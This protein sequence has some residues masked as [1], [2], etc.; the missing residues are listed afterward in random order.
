MGF[1]FRKSIKAGPLRV[2]ISKSGIGYSVGVKG[3]RITKTAKGNTR[4]TLSIPGTG[5]S[6]VSETSNKQKGKGNK[7][8]YKIESTIKTAEKDVVFVKDPQ[9]EGVPTKKEK[10]KFILVFWI[11]FASVFAT[12]GI[13]SILFPLIAIQ[14]GIYCYKNSCW[15]KG[16]LP[17][18]N[19]IPYEQWFERHTPA[20]TDYMDKNLTQQQIETY[21]KVL[22][23]CDF[24]ENIEKEFTLAELNIALN[25]TITSYALNKLYELGFLIKPQRG[26]F[27]LN[28]IRITELKGKLEGCIALERQRYQNIVESCDQ[29]NNYAREYNLKIIENRYKYLCL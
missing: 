6:Y 17:L 8:Q 16:F 9:T 19:P 10:N 15:R 20:L 4:S 21:A 22:E 24:G 27:A 26:K 29:Y 3:A 7:M 25:T 1:R 23:F 14:G 2:N 28:E 13:S 5:I 11:W 12:I 18:K